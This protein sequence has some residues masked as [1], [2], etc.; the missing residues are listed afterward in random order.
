MYDDIV[1]N[2]DKWRV[3]H[4]NLFGYTSN[5]LSKHL[6]AKF[7]ENFQ[8]YASW[9]KL[10]PCIPLLIDLLKKAACL[11]NLLGYIYR[12]LKND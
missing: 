11:Q 10:L 2:L 1:S 6:A 4:Q 8:D 7:G 9:I 3:P 12:W 5:S